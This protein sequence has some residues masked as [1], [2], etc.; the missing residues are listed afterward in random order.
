MRLAPT[1]LGLA[2]ILA[3]GPACKRAEADRP[4]RGMSPADYDLWRQ[5]DAVVAALALEAGDKVADLGAGRGY[6]TGRLARA[7]GPGGR[8]V[9][10]DI[11]AGAL[12]ELAVRVPRAADMAPIET[13]HVTADDPGLED[14]AFDLVLLAEVDHLLPDRAAYLGRLRAVLAAGGHLAVENRLQHRQ[15]LL[16]AA[17]RAGYRVASRPAP[18]GQF[19]VFLEPIP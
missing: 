14:G 7:V 4:A 2:A 1:A 9:A 18:P 6:L 10:T 15:G 16:A 13:R 5:P 17:A 8:V 3:V 19:L 12:A 11:D